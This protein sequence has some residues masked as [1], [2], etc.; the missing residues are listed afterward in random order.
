MAQELISDLITPHFTLAVI[1]LLT[2]ATEAGSPIFPAVE[3]KDE[4]V[5]HNR[6][7]TLFSGIIALLKGRQRSSLALHLGR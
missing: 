7:S 4:I 5:L 3:P 2:I 1:A 6:F